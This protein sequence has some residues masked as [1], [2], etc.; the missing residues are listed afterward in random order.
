LDTNRKWI[1]PCAGF[2][3]VSGANPDIVSDT[4]DH[5]TNFDRETCPPSVEEDWLVIQVPPV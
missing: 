4:K 5:K 3:P 2:S 1:Y